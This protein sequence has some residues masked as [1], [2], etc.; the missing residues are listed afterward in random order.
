M[1]NHVLQLDAS[2]NSAL[3]EYDTGGTTYSSVWL[4]ADIAFDAA[5]RTGL[6]AQSTPQI[7]LAALA[8]STGQQTVE[9]WQNASLLKWH[10][11]GTPASY[12][13]PSDAALQ[14][15]TV[16]LH[17]TAGTPQLT[18]IWVDSVSVGAITV[19][20]TLSADIEFFDLR[21]SG[22]WT[23]KVYI[24]NFKAGTTRGGSNIFS[25]DFEGTL[26]GWSFVSGADAAIITDP[27]IAAPA[28][29]PVGTSSSTVAG[30]LLCDWATDT[31][32]IDLTNS[33]TAMT[34]KPRGNRPLEI[35]LTVPADVVRGNWTDGFPIVSKGLRTIKYYRKGGFRGHVRLWN[36]AWD[37]D[38]NTANVQMTGY[39]P[40]AET[41]SRPV[42]DT[43]GNLVNPTFPSPISGAAILKGAI[44]NSVSNTGGAGDQEGF[45]PID[46]TSGTFDTTLPPAVDLAAE[47]TDWPIT[48]G[49]LY[50]LLVQTGAIDVIETPVDTSLGFP[51]G[52][53]TSLSIVNK[54]GSNLT[55]TI[56]FDYDTGSR[57]IAKL[58]R[59]DDLA[60]LCNKLIY[61]LGPRIDKEH[62]QGN[63]SATETT[64]VNLAA[65]LAI[66]TASRAKYGTFC[67]YKV[68]DSADENNARPLWHQLWETEVTLRQNGRELLYQTPIAE[69][70][71]EP[72]DDYNLF[73]T[74]AVN[75]SDLCGRTITGETQRI[76]GFDISME[77]EE[78]VERV[79]ELITS[80]DAE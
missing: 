17:S 39:S 10:W 50:A 48:I 68:Y 26:A 57:N 44:D 32:I 5:Y 34:V 52:I 55:G 45:I 79:G 73:D 36:A 35:T 49:D 11:N 80:A 25:D 66:E 60:T 29:G 28:G 62:W 1:P 54:A 65:W 59:V 3:V 53:I 75:A 8:S 58:R 43:T 18:E 31:T 30:F 38:E 61:E 67:E 70:T 77:G 6:L 40:M 56:H 4:T 21:A 9:L 69:F 47:L 2:T 51:A 71:W 23:G 41:L 76:Y 15:Y 72:F 19:T 13:P 20:G 63:I 64:P 27:G 24:D 14:F 33:F 7:V 37:L 12:T 78:S 74:V 46:T 16:E 42:R 22:G